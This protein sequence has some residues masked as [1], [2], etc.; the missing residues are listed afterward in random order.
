MVWHATASSIASDT[1]AREACEAVFHGAAPS[2]YPA[3]M[4]AA[5]AHEG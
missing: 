1:P 5:A 4:Q 2:A 3:L